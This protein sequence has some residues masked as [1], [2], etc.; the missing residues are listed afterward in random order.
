MSPTINEQFA[1]ITK[2]M[3]HRFD[4]SVPMTNTRGTTL[5][6]A[7]AIQKKWGHGLEF[8]GTAILLVIRIN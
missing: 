5:T 8:M 2:A 4:C 1:N 7:N 6:N 3:I